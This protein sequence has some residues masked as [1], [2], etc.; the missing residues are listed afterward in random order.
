MS[1]NTQILTP[2]VRVIVISVAVVLIV[3]E[4]L[5]LLRRRKNYPW[6]DVGIS[7]AVTA[8]LPLSRIADV[9]VMGG[10]YVLAFQHR[11]FEIQMNSWVS[12]AGLFLWQE[13]AFYWLHRAGHMVRWLWASHAVHHTPTEVMLPTAFR[14]PWTALLQ[15]TWLPALTSLWIGFPPAATFAVML[16]VVMYTYLQHTALIGTLGPLEYVLNTPAHHRVHHSSEKQHL[17]TNFG[18][19]LI[20]FDQ[21][22]GTYNPDLQRPKKYGVIGAPER[23][24]VFAAVLGEWR[25]LLVDMYR[26]PSALQA[27][28]I[29]LSKPATPAPVAEK[30]RAVAIVPAI[31]AV[32]QPE[33]VANV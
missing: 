17:D 22:F 30:Y 13:F 28:K 32:A 20:I 12:W 6:R 11:L 4:M 24:T 5:I 26:A 27:L 2:L 33:L 19:V 1:S 9:V 14:L 8:G 15:G 7:L 18:S 3:I 21:L 29:A 23:M 25:R 16:G 10:A 31:P